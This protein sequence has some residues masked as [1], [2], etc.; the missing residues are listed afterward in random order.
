MLI[1]IFISTRFI[2]YIQ[3][4]VD[5]SISSGAV[6][7]L[8]GLQIPAVAGFLIP[9][10]FF[11]AI[12]LTFGR[13]Y[14]ENEMVVI[15]SS[16]VN[17]IQ[18][19]RNIFPIA[20]V[21]SILAGFLSFAVTPWSSFQTKSLLAKE[22]AEARLGA[23]SPGRFQENSSKSGVV[24]AQLKDDKGTIKGIF[25]VSESHDNPQKKSEA[26]IKNI[27]I[28]VA[29]S[30]Q[31]I[32]GDSND[33]SNFNQN[34]ETFLVMQNGATYYFD[35]VLK[36]WQVTKYSDYFMRIKNSEAENLKLKT[37]SLSTVKLLENLQ[38]AEW[39]ELHWRL[40][41]PLS[42]LILCFLAIPL[43]RTEPRK[44]KFSRLFPAIM[45]YLVYALLMMN[46]RRLIEDEKIPVELGYWWIHLAAAALAYWLLRERKVKKILHLSPN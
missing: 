6:F 41:A 43:A 7:S 1:L 10:S 46:G 39:A 42:I 14:S 12:L 35:P 33:K 34:A 18:L 32:E 25:A 31:L 11:I 13:M 24:Y 5:G 16:G 3:L 22:K 36:Q 15:Q 19:A 17:E 37:K 30:A 38:P 2:K 8:L 45:I 29:E 20:L 26:D 27:Q 9:L 44:G 21:L 4:A 28:Q 40:S 23:F